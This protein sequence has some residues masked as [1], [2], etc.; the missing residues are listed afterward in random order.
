MEEYEFQAVWQPF[1][2]TGPPNATRCL[3][4][5]GDLVVIAT[6]ISDTENS[7][8]MFQGLTDDEAS[9]KVVGWMPLPRPM[10]KPIVEPVS[11][12]APIVDKDMVGG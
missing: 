5:D 7:T 1:P 9:F 10:E 11:K 2:I 8:W 6:Y 12:N 3:V 4:T